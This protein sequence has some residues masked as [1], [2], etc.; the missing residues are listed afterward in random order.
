MYV[1]CVMNKNYL[2]IGHFLNTVFC[3]LSFSAIAT[4]ALT[5]MPGVDKDLQLNI[6]RGYFFLY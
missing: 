4:K 6:Q 3:S 5:R 2:E 1:Y